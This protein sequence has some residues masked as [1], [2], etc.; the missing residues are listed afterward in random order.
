MTGI[1]NKRQV[2]FA[3]RH[4]SQEVLE[5]A[6]GRRD[7]TASLKAIVTP[8]NQGELG[9]IL[10]KWLRESTQAYLQVLEHIEEGTFD[11][12]LVDA[13]RAQ[14]DNLL[15]PSEAQLDRLVDLW[16]SGDA[17]HMTEYHM[18]Q[19]ILWV[20]GFIA[21]ANAVE[22]EADQIEAGESMG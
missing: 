21:E 20:L 11:D 1:L 7:V 18:K 9:G 14:E 19:Q 15:K 6:G 10:G 8:G 13:M 4:A 12:T 17:M 3:L 16:A 22:S 2:V 5:V